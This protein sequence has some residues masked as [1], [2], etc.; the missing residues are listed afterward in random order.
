MPAPPWRKT[1]GQRL[2]DRRVGRLFL[3]LD[4]DEAEQSLL[5]VG[6]SST[7]QRIG[8]FSL[9]LGFSIAFD[10][11]FLNAKTQSSARLLA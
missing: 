8:V 1:H 3:S 7:F 4:A 10:R 6:S 9:S 11:L 2:R 5:S